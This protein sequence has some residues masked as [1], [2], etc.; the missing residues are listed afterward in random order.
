[1][2]RRVPPDTRRNADLSYF[3]TGYSSF[4]EFQREASW[5]GERLGKEE[6]ELLEELQADDD[7]DRKPRSARRRSVWD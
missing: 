2:G 4:E 5:G 1:M 3:R 6:L 7:F